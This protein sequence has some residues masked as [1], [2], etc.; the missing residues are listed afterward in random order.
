MGT[1]FPDSMWTAKNCP[2]QDKISLNLHLTSM[3]A[4]LLR[5]NVWLLKL[6]EKIRSSFKVW[7][8]LIFLL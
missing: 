6:D 8:E 3:S 2:K 4:I 1:S 5:S 7:D